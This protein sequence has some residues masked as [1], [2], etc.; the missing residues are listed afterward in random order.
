M[1]EN[2]KLYVHIIIILLC[3]ELIRFVALVINSVHVN[4]A[5]NSPQRCTIHFRILYIY[6]ECPASTD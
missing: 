4:I 5:Y 6:I 1:N 3:N 2:F